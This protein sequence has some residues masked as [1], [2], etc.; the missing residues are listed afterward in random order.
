MCD[1]C[2]VCDECSRVV[3]GPGGV[4]RRVEGEATAGRARCREW[5]D[6]S[7]AQLQMSGV[8]EVE[9]ASVSVTESA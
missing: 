4:C 1:V 7:K 2:D 3:G 6:W 5:F 9:L 8:L